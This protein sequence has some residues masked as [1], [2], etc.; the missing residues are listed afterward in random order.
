MLEI[1]GRN[2]TSSI[3]ITELDLKLLTMLH[4]WVQFH[5][6]LDVLGI[7]EGNKAFSILCVLVT[8]HLAV[9]I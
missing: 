6:I 5:I 2:K 8:A 3:S 1:Y 4:S 9:F 7:Y